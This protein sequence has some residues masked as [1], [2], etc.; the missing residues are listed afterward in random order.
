MFLTLTYNEA[1]VPFSSNTGYTTLRKKDLQDF[2]K[3]LRK[4]SGKV[5]KQ[6]SVGEYGGEKDRPHYH[7]ILFGLSPYLQEDKSYV[8]N[9]WKNCDW[10]NRNIRV[11]SIG[12][13]TG[14]SIR[15]VAKYIMKALS[16]SMAEEAY[17]LKDRD[18]EFRIQSQGLG[19]SYAFKNIE[20]IRDN[21]YLTINGVPV[22]LPRYYID[23]LQVDI[24]EVKERRIESERETVRKITGHE[25]LS[26]DDAYRYLKTKENVVL[27]ESVTK[28]RHQRDSNVQASLSYSERRKAML[29][30]L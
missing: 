14:A 20:Q 1:T 22:S 3:R 10:S 12:S 18:P 24:D 9:S 25:G 4:N 26:Y 13:V 16:G 15:Y 2:F 30:R 8:Y 23:K 17:S 28:A 7:S 19:L 29:S 27:N 21:K 6:F 11:N 5:I